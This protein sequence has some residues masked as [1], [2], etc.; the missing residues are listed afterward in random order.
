[1]LRIGFIGTGGMGQHHIE[2]IM[3]TIPGAT[4]VAV[5]D[6]NEQVAQQV[7]ANCGARYIAD[8]YALIRAEDVDAVMIASWDPTHEGFS[9]AAIEAGKYVFCEKP[10]SDT[11]EGCQ[12]IM[13]AE[14]KA[15]KR[16]LQVGFMRRYDK[17]YR[18]LREVIASGTIGIP[19]VIHATHRNLAPAGG[20]EI[21]NDMAATNSL[22]HEF[23]VT[24]FLIGGNDTYVSA[25]LV[26]PRPSRFCGEG[27]LDPQLVYLETSSGIRIDLEM[28]WYCRYGYDIQCEVVG[29]LGTASLPAPSHTVVRC[30][31][32]NAFKVVPTWQERFHEAYVTELREWIASVQAGKIVG[33]SAWDGYV[34]SSVAAACRQSRLTGEIIPIEQVQ[35]PEFYQSI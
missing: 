4:V 13:E 9:I 35:C 32:K 25:Q 30:D 12:R 21:T 15:G 7:A 18:E 6:A 31:G 5:N 26:T 11:P 8:P 16:L 20:A 17:D 1:M 19:L 10:L 24:R 29:D 28:Y 27:L 22:V 3:S 2:N 34:A 33:P 14:M 23:D